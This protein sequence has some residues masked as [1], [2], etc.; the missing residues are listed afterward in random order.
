MPIYVYKCPL[1]N[2]PEE[3]I[4]KLRDADTQTCEKHIGFNVVM[5]RQL[6]AASF[7]IKGLLR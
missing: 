6:T 7:T 3:R 4:V 1:C 2:K 5:E